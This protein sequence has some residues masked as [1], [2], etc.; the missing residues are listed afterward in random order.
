[1]TGTERKRNILSVTDHA[2]TLMEDLIHQANILED[3]HAQKPAD[4]LRSIVSDLEHWITGTR[5]EYCKNVRK[6]IVTVTCYGI[7][8][9][10]ERQKAIRF[11]SDGVLSCDGSEKERYANILAQLTSGLTV[12]S[13]RT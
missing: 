6:D 13:D 9:Q 12:C 3:I 2:A 4:D 11:Y 10:M 8:E 5:K 1:M 7:T